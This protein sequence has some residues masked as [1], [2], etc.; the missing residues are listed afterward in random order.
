MTAHPSDPSV[1]S[2]APKLIQAVCIMVG[3]IF[4][5]DRGCRI[6]EVAAAL[7][8]FE[9]KESQSWFQCLVKI[10]EFEEA[11]SNAKRWYY[12]ALLM[13]LQRAGWLMH[14][15]NSERLSACRISHLSSRMHQKQVASM[16]LISIS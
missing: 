2:E 10:N 1:V 5:D 16:F 8:F 11:W 9:S 4:I 12:K 7:E 3:P 14:R 6:M 15:S 13:E